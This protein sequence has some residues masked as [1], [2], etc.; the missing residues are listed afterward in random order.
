MVGVV[1]KK[2]RSETGRFQRDFTRPLKIIAEVLPVDYDKHTIL[3]LFKRLY[4]LEWEKL[5]ARYQYYCE[6]DKQLQNIGKK[7]RYNHEE[8]EKFFFN[9]A[10][11]KHLVSTGQRKK[12]IEQFD[13]E[14]R[15]LA[16]N[17]LL[18]KRLNKINKSFK[19]EKSSKK[20][21]Q[22]IEPLFIDVFISAYHSK[23]ATTENKIEVFN[24]LKK[25]DCEKTRIFF[26]K[27]NDSERNDQ[28]RQMSFEHLQKIGAF[29]KLRQK[30]KGKVKSYTKATSDFN[31][32]SLDLLHR[33]D[34]NSVQ[35]K[36]RFNAFISHSSKDSEL[37][38]NL[39]KQLNNLNLSVYCDWTS[40][41]DFLR[42]D[43]V[44]K[45]TELVLKKR[46]QQSDFVI[47]IKTNNSMDSNQEIPSRWIELEIEHALTI[48]K[49]VL[50]INVSGGRHSFEDVGLEIQGNE[51]IV[52][53]HKI[54]EQLSRNLG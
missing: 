7:K 22:T 29:V 10:K 6:N 20:L 4:P 14:V 3:K 25:Y 31:V 32:S 16:F 43:L 24:E 9:L 49:P 48:G 1:K 8:P 51:F 17:T 33:I 11:V 21:I 37:V 46:I 34:S 45:Y 30:F 26:Q 41:N 50:C 52:N 23:C 38:L 47:F 27:L 28:I 35:N 54:N 12:Y 40:D 42:R 5:E 39:M 15:N 2:Y 18:T 36:K 53:S 19:K 13:S 44:S